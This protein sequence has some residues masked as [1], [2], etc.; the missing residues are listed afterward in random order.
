MSSLM[1]LRSIYAQVVESTSL[2]QTTHAPQVRIP[3][4][5]SYCE[6][7]CRFAFRKF[8]SV[9]FS[10]LNYSRLTMLIP[11][12]E[13][14]TGL[15][16]PLM[17]LKFRINQKYCSRHYRWRI[18]HNQI[19]HNRRSVFDRIKLCFIL[20]KLNKNCSNVYVKIKKTAIAMKA[21]NCATS[22]IDTAGN[23]YKYL[24]VI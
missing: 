10:L 17:Q 19:K 16:T 3:L 12:Q 14:K 15:K 24:Q 23:I 5:Q 18:A 4:D 1:Y 7:V 20:F 13:L 11:V 22:F 9:Y 21:G 2:R 6:K 8:F